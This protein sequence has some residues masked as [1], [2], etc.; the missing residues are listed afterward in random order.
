MNILSFRFVAIY[1]VIFF[2]LLKLVFGILVTFYGRFIENL[3]VPHF[4]SIP[5]LK[6]KRASD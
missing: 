5:G 3:Q 1:D 2:P 4:A 6:L